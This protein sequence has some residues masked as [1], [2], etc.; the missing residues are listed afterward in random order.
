MGINKKIIP[1]IS[2]II[3]I[4]TVFC[5]CTKND[6]SETTTNNIAINTP[7]QTISR[8]LDPTGTPDR[9]YDVPERETWNIDMVISN[10]EYMKSKS[11][12]EGFTFK[13]E[14]FDRDNIGFKMIM[15]EHGFD[16]YN[17][18]EWEEIFPYQAVLPPTMFGFLPQIPPLCAFSKYN[19]VLYLW[20]DELPDGKYRYYV[21]VFDKV[22][23]KMIYS[24]FEIVKAD[25]LK[26]YYENT[27]Q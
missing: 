17:G 4:S 18:N 8:T 13:V 22:T 27:E 14:I 11:G 1:I 12:D 2:L 3:V 21:K 10:I 26:A 6:V 9:P 19:T 15:L 24:E 23:E 20:D 16:Y 7:D 5:S 25:L